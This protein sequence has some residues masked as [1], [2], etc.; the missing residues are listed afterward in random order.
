MNRREFIKKSTTLALGT[1]AA[2]SLEGCKNQENNEE[3]EQ[4]KSQAKWY[5]WSKSLE[6]NPKYIQV[7]KDE[8]EL[9]SVMQKASQVR[10]MGTSHSYM[11]LVPTED[12]MVSLAYFNQVSKAEEPLMA[13]VGPGIVL[14]SMNR[15]L[16]EFGQDYI[17]MPGVNQQTFG[18]AMST[19]THGTGKDLMALHAYIKQIKLITANGETVVCS[20]DKES[21]IF[22]SAKVSLGLLGA[23]T[24]VKVQNRESFN[25]K[26]TIKMETLEWFLENG[27]K[28][29]ETTECFECLY[30]PNTG[31]VVMISSQQWDGEIHPKTHS[32]DEEN[33][34]T[35]KL[36]R[37][38]LSWSPYLRRKLFD[39]FTS[40][41]NV[42][43][44][45]YD[46]SFRILCHHMVTKVNESE[47]HVPLENGISC[48]G[49]VCALMDTFPTA[50]FFLE[51][52]RVKGDDAYMSPFYQR[53]SYSVSVHSPVEKNPID[54]TP[55]G[56][57]YRKHK[58]RPHWG[59]WHDYSREEIEAAYPKMQNFLDVRKMLDPKGKLLN[60]YTRKMFV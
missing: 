21:E 40:M 14:S 42:E 46:R 44:E 18:G 16:E 45:L 52:R 54:L 58:G 5:N 28:L 29:F 30:I 6:A 47:Y 50:F 32:N 51:I 55:F 26:Q 36:L 22:E 19:G 25:M 15:K 17:S 11:P 23:I 27:E 24:E 2:L 59:K 43:E 41:N 34:Q 38:T 37:D 33:I 48:F 57:I 12:T 20:K 8:K 7:P 31:K 60:D 56:A 1:S 39:W 10:F 9:I 3:L 49:E 13:Y 4:K 53:D 35:L